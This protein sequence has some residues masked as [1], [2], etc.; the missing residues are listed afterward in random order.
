MSGLVVVFRYSRA[1][2]WTKRE[3]MYVGYIG[4]LFLRA[5][6]AL[7]IP[8]IVSSLVSA[9]GKFSSFFSSS[10]SPIVPSLKYPFFPSILL[11]SHFTGT[12]LQFWLPLSLPNFHTLRSPSLAD[13][14]IF[15]HSPLSP[16][17]SFVLL[18]A[19]LTVTHS[20]DS[21]QL[22]PYPLVLLSTRPHIVS[23][24]SP[25]LNLARCL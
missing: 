6:K 25:L 8:L 16:S 12:L 20:T 23:F 17:A 9:I 19:L 18:T 2:P 4:E 13:L 11:H 1:E 15:P 21:L 14:T 24:L 22:C 3:V 5:L 10:K 7:I